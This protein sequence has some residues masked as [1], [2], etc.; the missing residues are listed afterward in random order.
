MHLTRSGFKHTVSSFFRFCRLPL[1]IHLGSG[2]DAAPA[3]VEEERQR[4]A[5]AAAAAGAAATAA[6]SLPSAATERG[7][8]LACLLAVVTHALDIGDVPRGCVNFTELGT[9]IHKTSQRVHCDSQS[10]AVAGNG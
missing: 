10:L 5:A 4:G 3:A 1:L 2:D 9:R 6:A 7:T 8:L